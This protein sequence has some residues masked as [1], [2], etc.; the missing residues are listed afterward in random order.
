MVGDAGVFRVVGLKPGQL[1][2]AQQK[3]GGAGPSTVIWECGA[4][5][6][7]YIIQG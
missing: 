5:L 1:V 3:E 2:I 6:A 7:N 4:V